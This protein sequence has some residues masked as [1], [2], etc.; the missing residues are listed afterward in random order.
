MAFTAAISTD[1]ATITLA[2]GDAS[3]NVAVYQNSFTT[4]LAGTSITSSTVV[5]DGSGNVTIA[6]DTLGLGTGVVLNGVW[7]FFDGVNPPI[8]LLVSA[9][10]DC[11]IAKKMDAYLTSSTCSCGKCKEELE[12]IAEIYLL[13]Q[14]AISSLNM[15]PN[16]EFDNSYIKYAKAIT[17]CTAATCK[18]CTC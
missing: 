13:L 18:S 16:P 3:N 15:L 17:L 4:P 14:T 8:G 5:L 11:C 7:K 1:G 9:T 2:G 12:L 6:S 10:V